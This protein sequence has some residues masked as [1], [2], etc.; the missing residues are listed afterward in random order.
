VKILA[1]SDCVVDRLYT[2]DVRER[3]PDVNLILGCGD[4]PFEYLEFLVTAFN[5]PL[6]YVPGN[7]D[8]R[9]NERL[10]SNQ[11]EGCGNLDL[12]VMKVQ[13]LTIAGIGGSIR[14]HPGLAN[15]YSQSEMY[16]RCMRLLMRIGLQRLTGGRSVDLVIAHSPPRGVHD[17]S[18]PAHIGFTAFVAFLRFVRPRYFLHGHVAAFRR[19]LQA[20]ETQLFGTEVLNINPYRLIEVQ[21][22]V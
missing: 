20:V 3:F 15:Q 7:H 19:N 11:A 10:P 8:P 5:V 22:N 21:P 13:G 2:A 9:F 6:L 4:L 18:D 16:F 17:D 12:R 1:V 14:Y